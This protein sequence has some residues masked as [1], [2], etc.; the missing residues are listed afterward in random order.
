MSVI[1]RPNQYLQCSLHYPQLQD[2]L[3]QLRNVNE[4]AQAKLDAATRDAGRDAGDI[5][6]LKAELVGRED[7]IERVRLELND[8]RN[9]SSTLGY[10]TP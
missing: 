6:R 10:V 4:G 3:K 9:Q 5:E 1:L 2:E 7:E 8:I